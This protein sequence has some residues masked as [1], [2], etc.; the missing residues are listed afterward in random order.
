MDSSALKM[1]MKVV[2]LGGSAAWAGGQYAAQ[3]VSNEIRLYA[4]RAQ[5]L[6]QRVMS[7]EQ[8]AIRA[9]AMLELLLKKEGLL[10]PPRPD[11]GG[12]GGEGGG[13]GDGG[14]LGDGG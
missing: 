5:V 9:E 1:A 11:G 10:P 2:L 12:D 6:E 7:A 8:S 3:N 4:Q 14:V 13:I